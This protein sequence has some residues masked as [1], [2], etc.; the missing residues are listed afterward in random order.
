MGGLGGPPATASFRSPPARQTDSQPDSHLLCS[1][2]AC[3]PDRSVG[4][5]ACW[6]LVGFLLGP[7]CQFCAASAAAAAAAAEGEGR[8]LKAREGRAAG[9]L[10]GRRGAGFACWRQFCWAVPGVRTCTSGFGPCPV[11]FCCAW[12]RPQIFGRVSEPG[13]E[14]G[15]VVLLQIRSACGTVRLA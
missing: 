13:D 4:E 5:L 15:W 9:G 8:A 2:S 14:C 6:V 1:I 12:W 7:G 10:F 3:L 11:R